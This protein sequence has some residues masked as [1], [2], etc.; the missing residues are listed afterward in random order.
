ME[1]NLGGFHFPSKHWFPSR[2]VYSQAVL[3][4]GSTMFQVNVFFL[5]N[6]E[7]VILGTR[8]GGKGDQG[9]RYET[10]MV[11]VIFRVSVW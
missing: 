8:G 1:T 9:G 7:G 6:I 2:I 5:G 3:S 4:G 11:F 10:P